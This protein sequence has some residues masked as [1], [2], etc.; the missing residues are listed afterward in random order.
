MAVIG[1]FGSELLQIILI[2]ENSVQYVSI[3]FE[4]TNHNVREAL[5]WGRKNCHE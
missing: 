5:G 2:L 4:C 1:I 3:A